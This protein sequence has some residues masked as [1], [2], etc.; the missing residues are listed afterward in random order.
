MVENFLYIKISTATLS[1]MTE[2]FIY[3]Q[4]LIISAHSAG[5]KSARRN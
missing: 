1:S 3:T 5:L 2:G 4:Q